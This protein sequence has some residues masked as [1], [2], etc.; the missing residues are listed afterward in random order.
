MKRSALLTDFGGVLTTDVFASFRAFCRAEGIEEEAVARRFR[1]D[2]SSRTLLEDLECG[3]LSPADFEARFGALL[4]VAS[5]ERLIERLFA[6]MTPDDAMI[7]ALRRAGAAGVRTGLLS[8]SWGVPEH[9]AELRAGFDAV[10]ISGEEGL[11][12]PDPRIYELALERL[13]VPAEEV[14][15]VDDLPFNLKPARELGMATVLHRSAERTIAELEEHL[16][17]ALR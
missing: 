2:P 7:A 17:V 5:H 3:R 13:G 8:N 6:G 9:Y 10:V 4:G 1:E 15:F 11:R 12:K 16:G 14:V